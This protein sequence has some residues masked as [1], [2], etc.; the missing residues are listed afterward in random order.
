MAHAIIN[1]LDPKK[2][3]LLERAVSLL[4][5]KWPGV[6]VVYRFGSWGTQDERADS[7]LDLAVLADAS[8]DAME[9]AGL[10]GEIGEIAGCDV[11]LLDLHA[12]S[13][14]MRAQVVAHGER[15]YC[16]AP[17]RCDEFEDLAFS[18]YARLNEERREI[19]RDIRERGSV[20]GG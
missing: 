6:I 17:R 16:A 15:I 1:V 14:V 9:R 3:K 2:R 19:L 11:D 20:Y 10:S 7:D 4:C 5:E 8:L 18:D 13:A 12:V